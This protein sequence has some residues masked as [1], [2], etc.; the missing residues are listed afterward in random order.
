MIFAT[1]PDIQLNIREILRLIN[2]SSRA[3]HE[4]DLCKRDSYVIDND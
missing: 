3:V 4:D 1:Q 2:F